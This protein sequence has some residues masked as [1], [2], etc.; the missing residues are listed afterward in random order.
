M[1]GHLIDII[2]TELQYSLSVIRVCGLCGGE[3]ASRLLRL[4]LLLEDILVFSFALILYKN[5]MFFFNSL[6]K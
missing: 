1:N 2:L 4:E 3:K 5:K 6:I